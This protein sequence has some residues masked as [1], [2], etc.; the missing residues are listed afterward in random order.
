MYGQIVSQGILK[1][2]KQGV[3]NE[4]S[5]MNFRLRHFSSLLTCFMRVKISK[6]TV[7]IVDDT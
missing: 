5:I 3:K 7:W 4:V 1:F 2:K 6:G